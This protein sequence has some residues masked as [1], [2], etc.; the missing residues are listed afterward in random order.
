MA[1]LAENTIVY[2]VMPWIK[3]NQILKACVIL[4]GFRKGKT[5][6]FVVPSSD[7]YFVFGWIFEILGTKKAF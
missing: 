6:N 2:S 4:F 5:E 1:E 7:L 3:N